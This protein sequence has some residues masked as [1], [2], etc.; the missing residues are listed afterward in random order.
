SSEARARRTQLRR[1]APARKG[2]AAASVCSVL[3]G[4]ARR[5]RMVHHRK[6]FP[7]AIA[8]TCGALLGV[9][10]ADVRAEKSSRAPRKAAESA[11]DV[12]SNTAKLESG[13]VAAMTEAL[14]AATNAGPVA[15][16]F[17][18]A[19]EAMLRRGAPRDI[20]KLALH[21]LGSIGKAESSAIVETYVHHRDVEL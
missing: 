4:S 8:L 16:D 21:A 11:F 13:N 18:P 7:M 6:V 5:R 12:R 14:D 19:I 1:G 17:A 2:F 9:F 3:V 15:G 20:A 10:G